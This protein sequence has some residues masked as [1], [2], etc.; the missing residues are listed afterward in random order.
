MLAGGCF[1][2]SDDADDVRYSDYTAA[3]GDPAEA[4]EAVQSEME[5]EDNPVLQPLREFWIGSS[6]LR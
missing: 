4:A 3:F 6:S 1:P 2:F 5:N